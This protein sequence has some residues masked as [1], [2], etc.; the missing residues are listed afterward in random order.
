MY[1]CSFIN[2]SEKSERSTS[3]PPIT[4]GDPSPSRVH[5][6]TKPKQTALT[7]LSSDIQTVLTVV[8]CSV[9]F[10]KKC[11]HVIAVMTQAD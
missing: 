9:V 8:A 1:F 11:C 5:V 7:H 4:D 2:V 3:S 10:Y 6:W